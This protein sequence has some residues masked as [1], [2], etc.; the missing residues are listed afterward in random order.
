MS[1]ITYVF[2]L[3]AC[4]SAVVALAW[5]ISTLTSRVRALELS[6]AT[7]ANSCAK[8]SARVDL[9]EQQSPTRLAAEVAALAAAVDTQRDIHQRFAG[10]VWQRLKG[11]DDRA[12]A[13]P[14][15]GL[16]GFQ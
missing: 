1:E 10:K 13:R 6:S 12:T 2:A 8:S 7:L 15:P 16:P 11:N 9:L 3:A 5:T 14:V 4:V